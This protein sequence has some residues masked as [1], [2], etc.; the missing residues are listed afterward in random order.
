MVVVKFSI[1]YQISGVASTNYKGTGIIVDVE[2]GLVVVDKETVPFALGDVTVIFAGSVELNGTVRFVHPLQNFTIISYD[3]AAVADI[4]LKPITVSSDPIDS[5]D[6]CYM[7]GLN[8]HGR[9]IIVSS[10]VTQIE[11][12]P[13]PVAARFRAT[14]AELIHMDHRVATIG[15]VLCTKDGEVNALWQSYR[16]DKKS[17]S[18]YGLPID[19][20]METINNL[21]SYVDR[22]ETM[23]YQSLEVE[24]KLIPEYV[25]RH[26]GLPQSWTDKLLEHNSNRRQVLRVRRTTANAPA[27]QILKEGDLVLSINDSL[28]SSFRDISPLVQNNESVRVTV[29]RDGEEKNFDVPTVSLGGLE[30]NNLLVWAGA[31]LQDSYREL[32]LSQKE[33]HEGVY[34]C[35]YY[36]GSP[37]EFYGVKASCW[38][39]A[40]NGIPTP[41][42]ST[43]LDVV[44]TLDSN[45][46]VRI[47]TMDTS[48]KERLVTL[49]PNPD[50]WPTVQFTQQNGKWSRQCHQ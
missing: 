30:P 41:N 33:Y 32:L 22:G 6:Q 7:V 48:D 42:L 28:V 39:M 40:L 8:G 9:Q 34:I 50:Y 27:S 26:Q 4:P 44:K 2:R 13:L 17:A 29:W 14:N 3:T 5:G 43:F 11:P 46:F 36:F 10:A 1:P 45:E 49:R 20:V 23:N 12:L 24:C 15:G 19:I 47:T 37:A 38:I 25:A 35:R 31:L 18:Y 16:L 21:R